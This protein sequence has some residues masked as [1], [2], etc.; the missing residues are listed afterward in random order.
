VIE[1]RLI[2]PVSVH[3]AANRSLRDVALR[4]TADGDDLK[5]EGI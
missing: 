5:I 1:E 4:V 2:A 3:L